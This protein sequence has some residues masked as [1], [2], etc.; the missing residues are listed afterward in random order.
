[1]SAT[2]AA[3]ALMVTSAAAIDTAVSF[4]DLFALFAG[5]GRE[6][7]IGFAVAFAI[8]AIIGAAFYAVSAGAFDRVPEDGTDTSAALAGLDLEAMGHTV[9][10]LLEAPRR[11]PRLPQ[12][13]QHRPLHA[14]F[15]RSPRQ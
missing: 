13:L 6:H 2:T 7:A 10:A 8:L 9:D 4:T 15:P 11:R 5:L 3:G 12:L 1:M 14:S